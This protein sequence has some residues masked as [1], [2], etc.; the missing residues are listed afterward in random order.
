MVIRAFLRRLPHRAAPVAAAFLCAALCSLWTPNEASAQ[1]STSADPT[2]TPCDTTQAD[3]TQSLPSVLRVAV[4]S[5]A[6]V[7]ALADRFDV[8]SVDLQGGSL[9]VGGSAETLRE[10]QAA[11]FAAEVDAAQ[12]EQLAASLAA[13]Q[14]ARAASC[15]AGG[16]STAGGSSVDSEGSVPGIPGYACYR[17]ATEIDVALRALAAAYPTLATV[18]DIGDSWEKATPGGAAGSDLLALVITN[19][20]ASGPKAPFVLMAAIHA[21]E[22]ATGEAALRFAEALLA[23]YGSDPEATWLLDNGVLHLLPMVNPDGRKVAEGGVLWRK[24]TRYDATCGTGGSAYTFGIDL[25]RN[26]TFAWHGCNNESCSSSY[27]CAPTYRGQSPASEPETQAIERYLRTVFTDQRGPGYGDIAPR[28]T[29][30]LF[31]SLHSYGQLVLRPWGHKATPAPNEYGLAAVGQRYAEITS[32]VSCQ[33]GAPGC[34]Y[35]TDGTTDDWVYG[36]FGVASHTIEMGL[37]FFESCSTFEEYIQPP[38]Q[39]LLRY[40]FS[41]ARMPYEMAQGPRVSVV[42]VESEA[43]RATGQQEL[44]VVAGEPL[45]ISA[46]L[47]TL[48]G[49]IQNGTMATSAE[50]GSAVWTLDTPPW[51]A[52]TAGKM[53]PLHGSFGGPTEIVAAVVATDAWPAGRHQ[54]WVQGADANGFIGAPKAIFV[55]VTPA[56]ITQPV[57]PPAPAAEILLFMPIAGTQ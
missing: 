41:I 23:G 53:E 16:A 40:A 10:L 50:V 21:R 24:N 1:S 14:A 18:V 46:R 25:N 20:Q 39:Q 17:T 6:E 11:G 42:E 47:E 52:E 38:I 43:D 30:G 2:G 44:A 15:G 36:T 35:A 51:L 12:T 32:Y 4:T 48:A 27:V 55:D 9:L 37:N 33:T 29:S 8:W 54:L 5:Q 26:S 34:L 45:T 22:L 7:D 19:K 56:P 57:A 49:D 13:M 31:M 28:S 3:P